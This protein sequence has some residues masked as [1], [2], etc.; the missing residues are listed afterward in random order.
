MKKILAIFFVAIFLQLPLI[1]LT[2][3]LELSETTTNR[4]NITQ[5]ESTRAAAN[6]TESTTHPPLLNSTTAISGVD[7]IST[8]IANATVNA[9]ITTEP[10]STTVDP[11]TMLIPPASVEAQIVNANITTKPSRFQAP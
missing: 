7:N 3:D 5:T 6:I 9:E 4:D 8:Q 10:P 11:Q 2:K 1:V